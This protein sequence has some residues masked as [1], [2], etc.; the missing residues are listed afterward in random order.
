MEL[1]IGFS[2]LAHYG[3]KGSAES[4]DVVER[5][6]GGGYSIILCDGTLN[7]IE[8]KAV[9]SFVL[10]TISG[11]I[12]DGVLDSTA[13]RATSDQLYTKYGGMAQSLLNIISIDLFTDTIVISRNNPYPIY[14][15]EREKFYEWRND[16]SPIGTA[17][18]IHPSITEIPIKNGGIVAAASD[19]LFKAGHLYGQEISLPMLVNSMVED[20]NNTDVQQIA[21]FIMSQAMLLDQGQP[22]NDMCVM[23]LR[24]S[25]ETNTAVSR[26]NYQFPF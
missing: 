26:V 15:Y 10:N 6:E 25:A 14:Y 19:G 9:S 5:P 12:T 22:Q 13:I 8:S 3:K 11:L 23:I 21:D 24:I 1:R 17:K 4:V 2:K 20:D 7:K 18:H 16:S